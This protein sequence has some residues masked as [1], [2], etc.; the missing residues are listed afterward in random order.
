MEVGGEVL[1]TVAWSSAK[2]G[3][4][5]FATLIALSIIQ[6]T[7]KCFFVFRYPVIQ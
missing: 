1:V 7:F 4:C 6:S 2:V 5:G 3:G